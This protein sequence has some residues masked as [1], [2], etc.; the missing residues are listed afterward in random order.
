MHQHRESERLNQVFRGLLGIR[1][2]VSCRLHSVAA[3]LRSV[4]SWRQL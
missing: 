4:D 1:F 2:I 3:R